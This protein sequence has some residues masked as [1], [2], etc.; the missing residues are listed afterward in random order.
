MINFAEDLAYW[1]LRFNGFF[2]LR[3]FVFRAGQATGNRRRT[4]DGTDSDLLAI[5]FTYVYEE[6]GGQ[7]ADWDREQ[8]EGWGI[9]IDKF[10]LAFIVEVTSA[11]NISH[12]SIKSKFSDERLK[13]AIWRFGIFPKEDVS[14][15]V[16]RLQNEKYIEKGNWIV[17]KLAVTDRTISSQGQGPRLHLLLKDAD[18]FLQKRIK[19]YSSK[20]S[21]RMYFPETLIQYLAWRENLNVR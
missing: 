4:A 10:H 1:Y 16:E 12:C 6:I 2:L 7:N 11:Q 13:Q 8:F 3:N 20:Y 19:A 14:C 9:E 15:L 21:D 18:I 5:R 17:A